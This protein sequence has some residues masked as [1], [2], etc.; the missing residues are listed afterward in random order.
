VHLNRLGELES[1]NRLEKKVG[2]VWLG[3]NVEFR[4]S[5]DVDRVA[6]HTWF[7]NMKF[8]PVENSGVFAKKSTPAGA[9]LSMGLLMIALC[10]SSNTS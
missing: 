8:G 7:V 5:L 9:I 3:R 10:D 6:E 1:S 4:T 2:M